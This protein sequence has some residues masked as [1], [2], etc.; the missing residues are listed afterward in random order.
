MKKLSIQNK[1]FTFKSF[2]SNLRIAKNIFNDL[3]QIALVFCFTYQLICSS[4]HG[5]T[6]FF[7]FLD[8]VVPLVFAIKPLLDKH[9]DKE[10]QD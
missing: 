8:H 3:G 6:S 9:E 10:H 7:D 4:M 2:S 5:Q 1:N